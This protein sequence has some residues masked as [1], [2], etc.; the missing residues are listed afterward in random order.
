MFVLIYSVRFLAWTFNYKISSLFF[1]CLCF[2]LAWWTKGT[3][4]VKDFLLRNLVIKNGL[5]TLCLRWLTLCSRFAHALLTLCS[6]F[7]HA[8]RGSFWVLYVPFESLRG[9]FWVLTRNCSRFAHGLLTVCSRFA[10]ALLM[11]CS[12]FAHTLLSRCSRFGGGG[13]LFGWGHP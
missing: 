5:L 10:Q 12:C 8:R 6:R 4:Q 3:L 11:L 9:L 2:V 7:T 13:C 1:G